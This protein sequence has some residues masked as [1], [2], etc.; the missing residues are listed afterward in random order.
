MMGWTNDVFC[1]AQTNDEFSV[2]VGQ[3]PWSDK[4]QVGQMSGRTNVGRTN[5]GN[6]KVASLCLIATIRIT[7]FYFHLLTDLPKL[8]IV[9]VVRLRSNFDIAV[10]ARYF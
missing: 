3:K 1:I 9:D 10:F 5:I 2:Q 8:T 6:K 7:F 4:S